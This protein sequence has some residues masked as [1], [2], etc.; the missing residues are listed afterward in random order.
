MRDNLDDEQAAHKRIPNRAPPWMKLY[1]SDVMEITLGLG[2]ADDLGIYTLM[3]GLA[4]MRGDASLPGDI[5]QLKEELKLRL[6]KQHGHTF[7]RAVPTLLEKF[8]ERR[9]DGRYYHPGVE[10]ELRKARAARPKAKQTESKWQANGKQN[11]ATSAKIN[12][13]QGRRYKD[14]ETD[15]DKDI[16]GNS[17]E[18]WRGGEVKRKRARKGFQSLG[19]FL[20]RDN[21]IS[22]SVPREGAT[23]GTTEHL[24]D[25]REAPPHGWGSVASRFDK[26]R[27]D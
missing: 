7:N 20:H 22:K 24:K 19:Q 18:A 5:G 10:Y 6:P 16:R 3:M 1:W 8:F 26:G 27:I 13:L 17:S 9:E 14:T 2:R 12:D 21:G 15:K 4:W 25:F 11:D 23:S